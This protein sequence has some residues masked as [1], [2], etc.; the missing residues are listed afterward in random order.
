MPSYYE[1]SSNVSSDP[2]Y[3]QEAIHTLPWFDTD[4]IGD[5]YLI[6]SNNAT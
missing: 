4:N 3:N 6:E 5:V 1:L 2:N